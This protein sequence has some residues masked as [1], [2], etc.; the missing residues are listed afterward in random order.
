MTAV[1]NPALT[2]EV[3]FDADPSATYVDAAVGDG[4]TTF[5][6]LGEAT[7][8]ATAA[9]SSGNGNTGSYIQTG[10]QSPTPSSGMFTDIAGS[11]SVVWS[12][13]GNASA[14][15]NSYATASITTGAT[16]S[17]HIL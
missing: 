7:G 6:R 8:A 9:D 3:A 12:N 1:S 16:A 5:L 4:P 2:V 11:G 14:A 17:H 10:L 15:D 13:P